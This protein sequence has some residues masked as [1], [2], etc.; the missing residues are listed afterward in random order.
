MFLVSCQRYIL[1]FIALLLGSLQI[2]KDASVR[3]L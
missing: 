3:M 1:D 2:V